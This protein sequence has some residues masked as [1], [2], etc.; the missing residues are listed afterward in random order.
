MIPTDE[1]TIQASR[2]I[3]ERSPNFCNT[4]KKSTLYWNHTRR[5]TTVIQRSRPTSSLRNQLAEYF[6]M[7]PAEWETCDP[8]SCG[9]RKVPVPY[10]ALPRW[11]T[12]R[13]RVR[14]DRNGTNVNI[15]NNVPMVTQINSGKGVSKVA[16]FN[17]GKDRASPV[18]VRQVKGQSR[19]SLDRRVPGYCKDLPKRGGPAGGNWIWLLALTRKASDLIPENVGLGF[20]PN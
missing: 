1:S 16:P 17:E 8:A 14:P 20:D 10:E 2:R 15:S 6:Q 5:F 7:H 3:I 9:V 18:N 12:G 4:S 13:T 19:S 11:Y